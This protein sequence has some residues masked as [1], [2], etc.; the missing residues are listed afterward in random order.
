MSL[1]NNY[2]V[3]QSGQS[4]TG[5]LSGLMQMLAQ[6]FLSKQA[7]KQNAALGWPTQLGSSGTYGYSA[8]GGYTNPYQHNSYSS[9][10]GLFSNTTTGY[11]NY[12]TNR[13]GIPLT[14]NSNR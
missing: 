7:I 9:N 3:Q 1:A 10:V 5:F 13:G 14:G 6:F 2:G 8:M 11:V 12:S 4:G